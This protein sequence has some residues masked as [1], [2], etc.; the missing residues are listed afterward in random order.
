MNA[1]KCDICGKFVELPICIDCE[2]PFSDEMSSIP[3]E[4]WKYKKRGV[5]D[6]IELCKECA[7][8]V[9]KFLEEIK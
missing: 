3:R 6:R 4:I 7:E 5:A 8:K 1:F 2:D 9:D